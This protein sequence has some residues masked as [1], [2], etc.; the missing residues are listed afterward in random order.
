ME[1]QLKGLQGK[2]EEFF[3][4]NTVD[5]GHVFSLLMKG[6]LTEAMGYLFTGVKDMLLAF[7]GSQKKLFIWLILV[8]IFSALL[9]YIVDA[10]GQKQIG[11][12]AFFAVFMIVTG[13]LT[14]QFRVSRDLCMEGME[15][16]QSITKLLGPAY[17]LS[18]SLVRGPA[19]A[20]SIR[21]LLLFVMELVEYIICSLLLPCINVYMLLS[22]IGCL[23]GDTR[24]KGLLSLIEKGTE[25]SLK[26]LIAIVTGAGVLEGILSQS[27]DQVGNNVTGKIIAMIP[28]I[29]DISEGTAKVILDSAGLIKNSM[30]VMLLLFILLVGAV[31][32]GKVLIQGLILKLSAAL[33]EMLGD[34]RI[35]L[36]VERMAKAQFMMVKVLLTGAFLFIICI[37]LAC[38]MGG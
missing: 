38:T 30:G 2:I 27:I 18:M 22:I 35:V 23:W 14:E 29:G 25:V 34:K 33:M 20:V 11:E 16:V 10:F 13:V 26:V 9:R 31:P 15:N 7:A 19:M 1:E 4:T 32:V 6:Q 37:A 17:L 21:L 8:G 36:L 3:P 5:L 28:G 12:L 24:L